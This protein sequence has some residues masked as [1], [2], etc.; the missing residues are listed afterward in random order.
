MFK[1]L[2]KI[3]EREPKEITVVAPI[4]GEI[5]PLEEVPD[6][7]FAQKMMGEGVA[8]KPANGEVISPVDGE[9][10]LVF[11]TKHA[12]IVEAE[13]NAE[14][15]IHIGLDTVNLEGEGFTAH[16]KDG[17][18]VKV[19]DKLMS[20]DIATI[21][22]KATSSITPIIISNTDNVREV[23]NIK[24]TEVTA[25]ENQILQVIN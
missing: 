18:I 25:G 17:D 3:K 2:F 10:K 5:I 8:V 4:T 20:F 14:I 21:E 13:N 12:I 1:N 11:Q 15:L 16:V 19:G 22:E 23:K 9:V 7:V 6:P 24:V